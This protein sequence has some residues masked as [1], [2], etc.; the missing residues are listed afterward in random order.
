MSNNIK[1]DIDPKNNK[2]E[3]HGYQEWYKTNGKIW[4]RGI[5]KN[6]LDLYY[7]ERHTLKITYYHIR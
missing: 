7:M 4:L 1:N 3:F 5:M 2:D 6:N